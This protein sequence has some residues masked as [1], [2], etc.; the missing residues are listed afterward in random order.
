VLEPYLSESP[1]Y[2]NSSMVG[3]VFFISS[4]IYI[5]LCPVGSI[6]ARKTTSYRKLIFL[7]C[8]FSSFSLLFIGPATFFDL[9]PKV[10]TTLLALGLMQM[11]NVLIFIP[12]LPEIVD[13]LSIVYPDLEED[14]IG[15][16]GSALY[17][18]F[19]A[20]GAIIGPLI[21]GFLVQNFGF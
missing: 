6:L 3:T 4:L 18:G 13:C 16:I 17:N 14:Y 19:Y 21:S 8:F 7:G 15:D 9:E 1:F 10:S 5:G 12:V 20:F 2:L 11:G